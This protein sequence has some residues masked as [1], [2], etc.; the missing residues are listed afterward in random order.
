M[1]RGCRPRNSLANHAESVISG[2]GHSG[3]TTGVRDVFT[4]RLSIG[5]GRV[6]CLA[7]VPPSTAILLELSSI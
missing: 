2:M 5:D 4:A 6:L 1:G 3:R 7:P